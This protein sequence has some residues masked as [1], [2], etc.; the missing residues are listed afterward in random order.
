MRSNKRIEDLIFTKLDS[1]DKKLDVIMI[2]RIPAI[3]KKVAVESERASR[4]AKT[5]AMAGGAIAVL[6]SL[7][8][9]IVVALWK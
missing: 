4:S 1:V 3:D 7:I 6:T 8:A 5:V 2:E 9:S